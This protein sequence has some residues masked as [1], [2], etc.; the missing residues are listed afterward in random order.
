LHFG[1][2]RV[3]VA[4]VVFGRVV[5]VAVVAVCLSGCVFSVMGSGPSYNSV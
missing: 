5:Y 2:S 1:V 4:D 3:E